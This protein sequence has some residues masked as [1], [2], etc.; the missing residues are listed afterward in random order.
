[1]FYGSGKRA[2]G[3]KVALGLMV[4][5][6]YSFADPVRSF[7]CHRRT[8]SSLFCSHPVRLFLIHLGGGGSVL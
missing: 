1:M 7:A 6:T 5:P 4:T 8:V 3:V 2:R